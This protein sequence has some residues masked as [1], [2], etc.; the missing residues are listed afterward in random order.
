MKG[1][2]I[3]IIEGTTDLITAA[4]NWI[5]ATVSKNNSPKPKPDEEKK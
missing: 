5:E 3:K 4:L 1:I 2:S